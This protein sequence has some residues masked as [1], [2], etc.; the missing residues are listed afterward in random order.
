M[1]THAQVIQD[2]FEGNGNISTWFGDDCGIN[3]SYANPFQTG[4]N[5]S[6]TVLRYHDT[7]GQYA[8]IRFD[9]AE[10]LTLSPGSAFSLKI[11]VPSDGITGNQPN[12]I[13]LKLQN[14][15]LGEP[16]TTQ[17]EII[18]PIEL[19]QWQTVTFDFVSD[20]YINL[21]AGSPP[22]IQRTDLNRVLLQVNG[23]NNNDE[24]VAYVDDFFF[25]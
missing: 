21:D 23:E 17:T 24:V 22:P 13:S 12:Q 4:D 10:N 15:T 14:N 19:D 16:W 9:V 5:T 3:T 1:L 8:N 6:T 25:D 11:Y 2:D 20:N 18:K 7:G